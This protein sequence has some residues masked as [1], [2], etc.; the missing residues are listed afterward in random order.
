MKR[1]LFA[2]CLIAVPAAA[3]PYA[4]ISGGCIKSTDQSNSNEIEFGGECG[5]LVAAELGDTFQFDLA[6]LQVAGE[7]SHRWKDLHG[8]NGAGITTADGEELNTTALLANVTVS[9]SIYDRVKIYLLGGLGV[10]YLD[11]LGDTDWTAAWQTEGGLSWDARSQLSISLGY[12]FFEAPGVELDGN[13]AD[14]DFHGVVLG[15][16]WQLQP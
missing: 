16:R 6:E 1:M 12:R 15:L 13:S 11:G 14:P 10:A 2:A 9:R 5:G 4:Q 3:E 8:Q 7:L